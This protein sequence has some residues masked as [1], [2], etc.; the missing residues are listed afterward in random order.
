MQ[1]QEA[2]DHEEELERCSMRLHAQK[3]LALDRDHQHECHAR[4]LAERLQQDKTSLVLDNRALQE[5]QSV[6]ESKLATLTGSE[7]G[8]RQDLEDKA[9][10]VVA[11]QG[12][13]SEKSHL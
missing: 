8:L 10:Q 3:Q 13:N 9:A 2:Q 4:Q 7:V 11:L 6:L 5:A 1:E 12:T